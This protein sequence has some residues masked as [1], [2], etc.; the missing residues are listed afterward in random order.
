VTEVRVNTYS[1]NSNQHTNFFKN[2]DFSNL[3]LSIQLAL[4]QDADTF[5]GVNT[6]FFKN[7]HSYR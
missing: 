7:D 6:D 1:T 4:T 2:P 3:T 5:Q